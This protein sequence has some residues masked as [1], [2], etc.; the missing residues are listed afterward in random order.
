MTNEEEEFCRAMINFVIRH[1]KSKYNIQISVNK[2][3]DLWYDRG[4]FC[5]VESLQKN[6]N[7]E[8]FYVEDDHLR[9]TE[10]GYEYSKLMLL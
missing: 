3:L 2:A 6:I 10:L 1:Y 5:S 7:Q 4:I 9:L 8:Y